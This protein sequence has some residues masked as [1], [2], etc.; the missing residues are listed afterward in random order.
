MGPWAVTADSIKRLEDLGYR[1]HVTVG[2]HRFELKDNGRCSFRSFPHYAGPKKVVEVAGQIP[3]PG[4]LSVETGCTWR[5]V[6]DKIY[7][8]SRERQV[9]VVELQMS[10]RRAPIMISARFNVGDKDGRLVLW[11]YVGDPEEER[12]IDFVKE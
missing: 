5:L 4:Y 2:D 11:D 3:V 12:Y 9:P 6:S 7:V 10:F 8:L 1:D